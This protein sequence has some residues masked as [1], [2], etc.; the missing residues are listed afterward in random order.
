MRRLERRTQAAV[1]AELCQKSELRRAQCVKY[2][3]LA[4]A[5]HQHAR[6]TAAKVN[7]LLYGAA[8]LIG[9]PNSKHRVLGAHQAARRMELKEQIRVVG[10]IDPAERLQIKCRR[11]GGDALFFDSPFQFRDV[12]KVLIRAAAAA[13]LEE[14]GE[15]RADVLQITASRRMQSLELT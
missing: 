4:A 12:C 15:R 9:A 10:R 13:L 6:R 7:D 8:A 5:S 11:L 2:D 1:L 14:R 3:G